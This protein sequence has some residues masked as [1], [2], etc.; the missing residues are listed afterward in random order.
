MPME[1]LLEY[2]R[3]AQQAAKAAAEAIDRHQPGITKV[4]YKDDD[5]P[6]TK[7][8]R[9]AEQVLR[10]QLQTAFPEHAIWGEEYGHD[11]SDNSDCLWLLDPIDGTK[12]WL[13]GLPFWSI[14]IALQQH[15]RIVAGV[16]HA[17]ALQELAWAA[18]G[19]GAWLNDVTIATSTVTEIADCRLS[20]GNLGSLAGDS[21]C[22]AA[23]GKLLAQCNRIRG[24]GDYYH[25]HRL[26]AGQLDAVI[27]SDVNILDIA[28]LSLLV[29]EAGGVFTD[30]SGNAVTLTTTSVL[31]AA[32]TEL[33][34]KI[35]TQ[36]QS[37]A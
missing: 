9:E 11:Q 3:T 23:Y 19:H 5:S 7:A 33:H 31:A 36:L 28:A 17:P 25:Y 2:I 20:A 13:S 32:N 27:E 15:D 22:W 1:K 37:H 29:Q 34:T 26:A 14:Q 18:Q 8:D 30:L 6:V 4:E 10:Q 24:Y 16:S 12:S 35:L 21:G